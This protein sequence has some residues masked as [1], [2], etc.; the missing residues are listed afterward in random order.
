MKEILELLVM[1]ERSGTESL[2]AVDILFDK[3]FSK[4]RVLKDI[5]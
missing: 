3:M 5:L 2:V 1:M 4:K